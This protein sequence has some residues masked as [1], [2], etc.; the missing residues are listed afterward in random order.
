[1]LLLSTCYAVPTSNTSGT[2]REKAMLMM[3]ITEDDP[4][5]AALATL[6]DDVPACLA[7]YGIPHAVIL[8]VLQKLPTRKTLRLCKPSPYDEWEI[9]DSAYTSGR[10]VPF[11]RW[12][13]RRSLTRE[14]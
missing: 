6:T 14:W 10:P 11:C 13:D 4:R 3:E 12:G 2:I 7:A 1:M 9:Q 8:A 5:P